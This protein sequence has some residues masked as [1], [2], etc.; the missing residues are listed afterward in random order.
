MQCFRAD[1][2]FYCVYTSLQREFFMRV[3]VKGGNVPIR[4]KG[5]GVTNV[6]KA[7][8]VFASFPGIMRLNQSGIYAFV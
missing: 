6:S 4:G 1:T 2:K 5:V 8:T 3:R 7:K